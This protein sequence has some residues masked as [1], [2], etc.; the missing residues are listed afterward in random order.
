[1]NSTQLAAVSSAIIALYWTKA[2]E[3]LTHDAAQE[4]AVSETCYML[5]L[6]RAAL[7]TAMEKAA[8]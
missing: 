1:M 2:A 5:N 6:D 3:G 4:F 7:V 8:A